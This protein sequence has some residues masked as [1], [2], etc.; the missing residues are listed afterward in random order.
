MNS[1]N[2]DKEEEIVKRNND[3]MTEVWRNV[4][5]KH[6]AY[7]IFLEDCEAQASEEWIIKLQ[8]SFSEAMEQHIRYLSAKQLRRSLINKKSIGKAWPK[9][10]LIRLRR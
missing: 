9:G 5:T 2:D 1:I 10:T 4:E 7:K 8:Q 3:E 6:D